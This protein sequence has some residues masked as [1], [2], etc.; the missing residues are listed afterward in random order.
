MQAFVVDNYFASN[1]SHKIFT[2]SQ[3]SAEAVH[4]GPWTDK[5]FDSLV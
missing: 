1:D 5:N 2:P 3:G 4:V